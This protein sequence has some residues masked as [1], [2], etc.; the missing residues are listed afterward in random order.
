MPRVN[1]FTFGAKM[2]QASAGSYNHELT[3]EFFAIAKELI[4]DKYI[5]VDRQSSTFIPSANKHGFCCAKNRI[6]HG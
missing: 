3:M 5:L 1:D 4:G 6:L 2:K